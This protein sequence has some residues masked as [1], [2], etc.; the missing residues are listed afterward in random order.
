[1]RKKKKSVNKVTH[2]SRQSKCKT[3]YAFEVHNKTDTDKK[4][5][6]QTTK[7]KTKMWTKYTNIERRKLV[8]TKSKKKNKK[9]INQ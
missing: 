2:T 5:S 1:M 6:N 7:A 9:E 4:R 8:E 3:N